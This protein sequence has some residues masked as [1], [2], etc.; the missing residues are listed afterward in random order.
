MARKIKLDKQLTKKFS[1]KKSQQKNKELAIYFLI[2]C[3]GEKTEPNYFKS[4]PK[5]IGK[6]IY[7]LEFGGGNIDTIKVVDKAI[8]LKNNSRQKYD[9]VWAV[10]DK[11][12][13]PN[14]K[15]NN[16]IKKAK[17]NEIFCAW[18]NEA[19]ELWFLL[20][21]ELRTTPMNREDYKKQIETHINEIINKKKKFQYQKNNEKMFEIL[22]TYGNQMEA[23]RRAKKLEE[24]CEGENYA[25][26]NPATQVYKL[27]EELLG[28]SDVL[29]KEIEDK[30]ERG[31]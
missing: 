18:S 4:F 20:H 1:P 9:R 3:E 8:E 5:E 2:V 24:D 19:F 31:E 13:F 29:K 17:A 14:E 23:I 28:N 11:D 26:F 25:D 6:I 22:E 30:F 16:A 7:H 12:D 27:V 15:F 10:F 21:F